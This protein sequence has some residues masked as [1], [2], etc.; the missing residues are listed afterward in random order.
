[1]CLGTPNDVFEFF[2]SGQAPCQIVI[3][4]SVAGM[5]LAGMELAKSV[6]Q[7]EGFGDFTG[8][9]QTFLWNQTKSRSNSMDV[10]LEISPTEVSRIY[11][12]IM[13]CRSAVV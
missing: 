2:L 3:F 4:L 1:M 13:V 9:A 12:K 6:A 7:K 8:H 11:L 10:V 5:E